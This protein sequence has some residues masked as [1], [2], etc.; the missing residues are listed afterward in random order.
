MKALLVLFALISFLFGDDESAKVVFDLT[1]AKVETFE[2][3]ILK[4][5]AVNKANFE[6]QFKDFEVAVVIHGGSY[7]FFVNDLQSTKYKDDTELVKV[8]S[9]LKKRI[10]SM[11]D[12]YGVKFYMCGVGVKKHKLDPKNIMSFVKIVPNSTMALIERQNEGFAYL[13][14]RDY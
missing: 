8:H 5:V 12:T 1:T 10:A 6:S 11:A 7:R 14:V 13:P 2:K 9:E 3:H 4:G